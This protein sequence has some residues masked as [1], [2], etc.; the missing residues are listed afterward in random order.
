MILNELHGYKQ[1]LDK[2]FYE[3]MDQLKQHA[4][5]NDTGAFS[6][7]VIP[8]AGDA[9]YKVWTNDPGYEAFY[10]VASSMQSNVFVPKF[11]RIH[12]LPIFFK[13][14]D[15]V[16]GFLK[17]V[18]MERLTPMPKRSPAA[19]DFTGALTV[20][21]KTFVATKVSISGFT[22]E[23]AHR[24]VEIFT[25]RMKDPSPEA[26]AAAKVLD[27]LLASSADLFKVA[28]ALR[29][30]LFNNEVDI[31]LDLH[32]S[33]LMLRGSQ[34]VIIDP[35]CMSDD[36][37]GYQKGKGMLYMS[38]LDT[39]IDAINDAVQRGKFASTAIKSGSRPSLKD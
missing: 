2:D 1:Y 27:H 24:D 5:I 35:F 36:Y 4:Y 37:E 17:I 12:R 20:F 29:Q 25:H 7:V 15:T 39:N 14:P 32:A 33:N 18:K 26:I 19:H 8:K 30:V 31:D 16:D 11:G 21:L 34:P 9:V 3:L 13:R 22:P 6:V 38:H 10:R 23:H 28:Q